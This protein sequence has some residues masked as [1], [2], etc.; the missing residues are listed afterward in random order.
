VG[1]GVPAATGMPWYGVLAT[2]NFFWNLRRQPRVFAL[3]QLFNPL[4]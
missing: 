3:D 1:D 4:L 2:I